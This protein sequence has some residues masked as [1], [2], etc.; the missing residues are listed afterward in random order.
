MARHALSADPATAVS[1]LFPLQGA[2]NAA[3][4]ALDHVVTAGLGLDDATD[5]L[6]VVLP[7]LGTCT[8]PGEVLGDRLSMEGLA[9]RAVRDIDR[10]LVV[11][12]CDRGDTLTIVTAATVELGVRAV[13]GIDPTFGLLEVRAERVG[14][15]LYAGAPSSTWDTAVALA[16]LALSYEI[17]GAA[18]A[19]LA[20]AC[21]HALDR[22]QYGQPISKF[23]AVRHRLAETLVAIEA[24]D[25]VV[26]AT[27]EAR[28]PEL[29]AVAK[30]LAG[31]GAADRGPPL[32][33]GPRR[34]RVHG[35][36]PVPPLLP[37]LPLARSAVRV[38][39]LLDVP[40]W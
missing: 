26:T 36:A 38:D 17:L 11:A 12:R 13:R 23:Q 7:P 33:T 5:V 24:A 20:L 32:P 22:I 40:V 4:S 39:A 30:A 16:Q 25:A 8:V 10:V 18:R 6:G 19:M 9:T 21:A 2:A 34:H 3:S 31:R 15:T 35:R 37:P 27:R 14:C 1:I 28:S 29:A